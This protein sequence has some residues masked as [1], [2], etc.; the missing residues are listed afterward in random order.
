MLYQPAGEGLF[1][2]ACEADSYQALVAALLDDPGYEASPLEHRL[3]VRIRMAGD[4]VLL[5]QLEGR[6]LH[7]SDREKHDSI[8]VHTDEEFIRSLEQQAFLSLSGPV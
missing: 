6:K 8:N 3:Q 5:G 2:R 4:L 7:I 1:H